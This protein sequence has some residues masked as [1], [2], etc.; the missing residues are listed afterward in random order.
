MT[1]KAD[2]QSL[3]G[4]LDMVERRFPEEIVRIAVPV[5]RDLDITSAVFEFERAGKYPVLIFENVEG[6]KMPVVTNIAGNRKLLAACLGVAPEN[7][8]NAFRERCQNYLPV[9]VVSKAP[10]QEVVW[11]GDEVDLTRLPIPKHFAVDAAPYITA[12][13]VVARD[14]ESNVDTTGF[15]RLMLKGKNKLGLSLHS[16]RR[17]YEFHRRAEAR[18]QS[19]PAAIVLGIHPIHYMGS[20]AYHYPPQVRKF[21]IIGGLFG[22]PYR[23]ARCGTAALEVPVGAEIVIEGEILNETREPEGPFGEFTGYASYRST[24]N[25]FVAKRVQMRKDALF[26]SIASG[27]ANDHILVSCVSREAEILNA[28]KRNLPNVKAVHVPSVTAGALLAIIS[29]KKTAEGQPRQAMMSAFG[30]EFY[31]KSVVVVDEDVD[32]FNLADVAWAVITRTRAEKDVMFVPGAMGAILDPTSDPVDH[33]VTKV[34]I[35][36]TKPAGKDFAERLTISDAQRARVR[37]I[38]E[39]A[40][41]KL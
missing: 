16:R 23:V 26:H 21:E 28:L 36:A 4:F 7:M 37:A 22:A 31:V 1:T 15:H 30:T 3:R 27:M 41:I 25:V 38:I 34:G 40:G 33:T 10:W 11:E 8:P 19:L 12:G 32:I 14:P 29:M 9:E 18:G 20:M 39:R 24:Q 2:D 35:D 5:S 6:S 13:Q 17:M